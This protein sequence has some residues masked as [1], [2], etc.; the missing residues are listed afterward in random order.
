MTTSFMLS[1]PADQPEL[2]DEV[3]ATLAAWA[4]VNEAPR[5]FMDL[6]QIKLIVEILA[7]ITTVGVGASTL[8]VNATAIITFLLMLKDRYEKS[9]KPSGIRIA[10]PG[11]K[12]V[13]LDS[14]DE[15]ILKKLL[16]L[17]K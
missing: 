3:E 17:D 1:I 15:A 4:Q 13:S 7:D 12:D 16:K 11:Q 2:R 10:V 5:N 8:A 6:N 14:V 9:K